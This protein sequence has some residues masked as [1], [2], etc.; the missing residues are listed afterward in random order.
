[1]TLLSLVLCR[2]K[3]ARNLRLEDEK[4]RN[5]ESKSRG[6]QVLEGNIFDDQTDYI[7]FSRSD[8]QEKIYANFNS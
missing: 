7:I 5:N 6:A 8:R 1:M 2:P 3:E 4:N